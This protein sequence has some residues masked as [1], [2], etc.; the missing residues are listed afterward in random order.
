MEGLAYLTFDADV[1][2]EFVEDE[3][4][5]KALFQLSRVALWVLQSSGTLSRLW[6]PQGGRSGRPGGLH[7]VAWAYWPAPAVSE[8]TLSGGGGEVKCVSPQ[9]LGQA[10]AWGRSQGHP[11]G[12]VKG[13]FGGP[14]LGS[15]DPSAALPP[16]MTE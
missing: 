6:W 1:K 13:R 14:G 16:G 5:L 2:E 3:A 4:A 10:G 8:K 12:P 7:W 11:N 15:V 9:S